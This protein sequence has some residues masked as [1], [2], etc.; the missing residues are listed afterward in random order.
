MGNDRGHGHSLRVAVD[1]EFTVG[2][3]ADIEVL[4]TELEPFSGQI[5]SAATT[6]L[7][8]AAAGKVF[9]IKRCQYAVNV[10]QAIADNP[11]EIQYVDAD[12]NTKTIDV[13]FNPQTG[14]SYGINVVP[15]FF[16]G[17]TAKIIKIVTPAGFTDKLN[18]TLGVQEVDA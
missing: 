18:W 9:L 16:K 17:G 8:T 6:T 2:I 11:F 4:G 15:D 10:S 1:E 14:A 5:T 13:M 3:E 12:N 7:A